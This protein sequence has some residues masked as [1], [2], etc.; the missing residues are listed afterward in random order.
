MV[1]L[2]KDLDNYVSSFI[3]FFLGAAITAL[4]NHCDKLVLDLVPSSH[5]NVTKKARQLV[6]SFHSALAF[7]LYFGGKLCAHMALR[8]LFQSWKNFNKTIR[9]QFLS[10]EEY[11]RTLL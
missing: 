2:I 4:S 8:P 7:P 6:N 10:L 9:P 5:P 11:L 1:N 3:A